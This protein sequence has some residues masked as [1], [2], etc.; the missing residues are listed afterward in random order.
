MNAI[1]V[2]SNK[3]NAVAQPARP[4][5][6]LESILV[7]LIPTVGMIFSHYVAYPSLKNTGLAPFESYVYAT[8]PVLALMLLAALVAYRREGNPWTREAFIQRFRL[9]RMNR[10]MWLWTAA[11]IVAYLAI[12]QVVNVILMQFYHAFDYTPYNFAFGAPVPLLA[13]VMLVFNIFGEEFWWRGIILPRQERYFGR[14]A[15]L[16][17]GTLWAFF[18]LYKWWGL[19]GLLIVCQIIPFLSQRLKNNW[20]ALLMHFLL[21]GLGMLIAVVIALIK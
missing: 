15:W 5:G 1:S 2:V 10:R 11:A 16:V 9:G 7:V 21:N 19:P 14:W 17:N 18:H 3:E 6:W 12:G 4:M 8:V 13:L 20:P